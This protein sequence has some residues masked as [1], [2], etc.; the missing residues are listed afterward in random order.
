MTGE[1]TESLSQGVPAL[2]RTKKKL[3]LRKMSRWKERLKKN[4]QIKRML[5]SL[6]MK[7]AMLMY[8]IRHLKNIYQK[9]QGPR[10][11]WRCRTK[12]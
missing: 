12:E 8:L 10:L 3:I 11:T 6:G 5:N 4:L 9:D 2:G 7:L 1:L